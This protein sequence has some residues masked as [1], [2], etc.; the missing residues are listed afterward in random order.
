MCKVGL[1]KELGLVRWDRNGKYETGGSIGGLVL[2]ACFQQVGL[3]FEAGSR[4][5]WII[6]GVKEKGKHVCMFNRTRITWCLHVLPFGKKPTHVYR[7]FCKKVGNF[8]GQNFIMLA[9]SRQCHAVASAP[10]DDALRPISLPPL[11][12]H[13][14]RVLPS[15]IS[16]PWPP[17]LVGNGR[18]M[19]S[20]RNSFED[21]SQA[22]SEGPCRPR[23]WQCRGLIFKTR[24]KLWSM[25]K[26]VCPFQ[27]L[28][29][30]IRYLHVFFAAFLLCALGPSCF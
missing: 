4:W 23:A 8:F 21:S 26:V 22:T 15:G 14:H 20:N 12:K 1:G 2:G 10:D 11:F 3:P 28:E 6:S 25:W 19:L 7:L 17:L 13:V 9:F 5:K 27:L 18:R 16:I 24:E 29:N 30:M